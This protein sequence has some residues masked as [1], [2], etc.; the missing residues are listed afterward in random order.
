MHLLTRFVA[1]SSW[2]ALALPLA[3]G[4]MALQDELGVPRPAWKTVSEG[5]NHERV[6]QLDVRHLRLDVEVTLDD[7]RVAG[8]VTMDAAAALPALT[9]FWLDAVA[10]TIDWVRIDGE[11][12]EFAELPERLWITLPVPF[13]V[14]QSFEVQIGYQARPETGLLWVRRSAPDGE[15]IVMVHSQG[16]S[17]D[18]RHWFPC[19]D[20][21]NDLLTSEVV[22]TLP[23]E[24]VALSNGT[25][26][27]TGADG[28]PA[29]AE[30]G[31]RTF[32]WRQTQ[33]HANYLITLVIGQFDVRRGEVDGIPLNDYAPRGQGHLLE[34]TFSP[35]AAMMRFLAKRFG[36]EYPWDRYDQVVVLG[37]ESG[38]MENTGQ[39]TLWE[40]TLIEAHERP[41]RSPDLLIL[42]ELAHQWFG[43]LVTCA[44]WSDL[45]IN[46]GFA[47]YSEY[48]WLT[49]TEGRAA[50]DWERYQS[51]DWYF[52]EDRESHRRAIIEARYDDP[53]DLF[54]STIYPKAAWV[55][56]MLHDS[57]GEEAF[58]KAVTTFLEEHRHQPVRTIELRAAFERA[59]GKDL[60]WFFEQWLARP[61][62]PELAVSQTFHEDSGVLTLLVEQKQSRVDGTPLFRFPVEVLV[63]TIAGE[64]VRQT[65][66]ISDARH[67]LLIRCPAEPARVRFD[68][69]HRVLKQMVFEKP[70][71]QW[72]RQLAVDE[73]V[74]ARR[75][76][77]VALCRLA[78]GEAA[79]R[80][81]LEEAL[82]SEP[83]GPLRAE[84]VTRLAGAIGGRSWSGND[85]DG[86]P[87]ADVLADRSTW[88]SELLRPLAAGDSDPRVRTASV[89]ALVNCPPNRLNLEAMRMALADRRS[90]STRS[91][92]ARVLG[93]WQ[94]ASEE[95][96]L[97]EALETDT[98]LERVER[99]ALRALTELGV[100]DSASLAAARLQP[101][102]S[103]EV[104]ETAL[105]V[106]DALG[107][108][109]DPQ[110][111]ALLLPH[112]EDGDRPIRTGVVARLKRFGHLDGELVRAFLS[113]AVSDQRP[114]RAAGF[115]E[116]L[117][118]IAKRESASK[119]TSSS[120]EKQTTEPEED[121]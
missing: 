108:A 107:E 47:N 21:P 3:S 116:I 79:A 37:Y 46:E 13:A 49:E 45:W 83:F 102:S 75:E 56:G 52:E 20:D 71:S 97:R 57:V 60:G 51:V 64:T 55:I 11:R 77:A 10:M 94:V 67:E 5:R 99:A 15:P 30:N 44:T 36:V 41:E 111:V 118:A 43:D 59:S 35:T 89:R 105:Q 16:E 32:H 69:G 98:P 62:H 106:L 22:L 12:A 17:R 4:K 112:L 88:V 14:G 117:E 96:A 23:G 26:L 73:E 114:R 85:W 6:R 84:I 63:E 29:P 70:V 38:G 9:G 103:R 66:E 19:Y 93:R 50:S 1:L 72:R 54:D 24:Y 76:A 91:A 2:I 42:H 82:R 74:L 81:A 110:I 121:T 92:A 104:R 101:S 27:E 58:A 18:H 65:F 95:P 61:G 39:T 8:T 119:E 80:E 90:A 7:E 109:G 25:L 78:P 33:P 113:R 48:L 31:A 28:W 115:A 86:E 34:T 40:H 68:V 87:E 100:A 53:D 120:A